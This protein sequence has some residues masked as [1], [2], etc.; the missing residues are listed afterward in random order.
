MLQVARAARSKPVDGGRLRAERRQ[1]TRCGGTVLVYGVVLAGGR[2]ER[3]WPLSRSHRPKQF[4]PI[5]GESTLLADTARRLDI[6]ESRLI[7]VT[8]RDQRHLVRESLPQLSPDQILAEPVGRNTAPAVALA[9]AWVAR[10]DPAGVMIVVPSDAWVGDVP[11]YQAALIR[12]TAAAESEDA[13]VTIGIV[14]S[15]PETGYGYLELGPSLAEDSQVFRVERFVEKPDPATAMGYLAGG[16]HLWNCGIFVMKAGVFLA[17]LRSH[18]PEVAGPLDRLIA[19]GLDVP[20]HLETYYAEVPSISIDYGVMEKARNVLTVRGAFPWD[21]LGSWSALER[22]I[23]G[24]DGVTSRG[25]VLALD[26]PGAIVYSEE[27]IVAVL[28]AP[29]MI[30]VRTKDATLVIP[31]SRAQDVRRIVESL[32]RKNELERYL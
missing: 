12:A 8:G 20:A 15:R 25:D 6:P 27:G 14:P 29:D 23:P 3:F 17:A 31:K 22:V 7:V 19:T 1:R 28:G 16:L 24:K 18:L 4:L 11:A 32:S 21:D 30:V 2:G 9:A 10:A 5:A 13:L 26:S